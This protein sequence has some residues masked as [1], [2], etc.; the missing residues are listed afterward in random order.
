[1]IKKIDKFIY[2]LPACTPHQDTPK[3]STV[4]ILIVLLF[5]LRLCSVGSVPSFLISQILGKDGQAAQTWKTNNL[6]RFNILQN[7]FN[8]GNIGDCPKLEWLLFFQKTNCWN[9]S[10]LFI[11]FMY[12]SC[13]K[14]HFSG[15]FLE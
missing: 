4:V 12:N 1:M 13:N 6:K 8:L 7:I 9:T 11:A 3:T 15:K 2:G 5:V 14:L 10:V